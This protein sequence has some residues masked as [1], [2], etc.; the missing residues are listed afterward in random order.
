VCLSDVLLDILQELL[1]RMWD[2]TRYYRCERRK[3]T[4]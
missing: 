4:C 2:E 3:D 1:S